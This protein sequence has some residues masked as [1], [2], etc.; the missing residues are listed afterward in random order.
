MKLLSTLIGSI[1]M[2]EPDTPFLIESN[3]GIRRSGSCKVRQEWVAEMDIPM[4]SSCPI[5]EEIM[6]SKLEDGRKDFVFDYDK[7]VDFNE[8]W[9]L[10]NPG[11]DPAI[12]CKFHK[13]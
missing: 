13:L 2:A 11:L 9:E 10:V 12:A 1:V 4:V 8:R 7:I 3:S 5:G 6:L